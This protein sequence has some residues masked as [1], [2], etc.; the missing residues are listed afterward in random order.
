MNDK[1]QPCAFS[2]HEAQQVSSLY[3]LCRNTKKRSNSFKKWLFLMIYKAAVPFQKR[4]CIWAP[5]GATWLW[6]ICH[7][8][9][10][11]FQSRS[12]LL[13]SKILRCPGVNS[14]ILLSKKHQTEASFCLLKSRSIVK[15]IVVDGKENPIELW[16]KSGN[17][18]TDK[19][20]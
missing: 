9:S 14:F 2:K 3:T 12:N 16:L 5:V 7:T 15:I 10:R 11:V 13:P 19:G 20:E 17:W 18:G 6:N 4:P 1:G 8:S